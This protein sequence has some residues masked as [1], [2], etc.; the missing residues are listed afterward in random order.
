MCKDILRKYPERYVDVVPA[1]N[2]V[3]KTIDE[4][5]GKVAVIWMVG[6]YGDTIND[7]PYILEPL[8]EG[9]EDVSVINKD[10]IIDLK[11][12]PRLRIIHVRFNAHAL[13]HVNYIHNDRR[14]HLRCA[15]SC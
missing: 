15:L 10:S 13:A 14:P 11:N 9:W 5:E 12:E 1:L 4:T 3:L 7:A 6:E 8:I 2:K